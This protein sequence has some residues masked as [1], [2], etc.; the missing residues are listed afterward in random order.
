MDGD[1]EGEDAGQALPSRF[2]IRVQHLGVR[3]LDGLEERLWRVTAAGTCAA[4]GQEGY[5]QLRELLLACPEGDDAP[6][7]QAPPRSPRVLARRAV[8]PDL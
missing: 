2:Q 1:L 4:P 6:P 7:D 3:S 8:T 5:V